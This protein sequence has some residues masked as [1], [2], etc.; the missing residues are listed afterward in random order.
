MQVEQATFTSAQRHNLQGYHLVARSQGIS[1]NLAQ[2]LSTWGPS[3]ASLTG[4]SRY[5][6]SLNVFPAGEGW[7]A[8][9]RTIFGGPEYSARGGLQVVT[10]Y[11]VFRAEQLAG[12]QNNFIAVARI[13]LALGE[14]RL[15]PEYSDRLPKVEFPDSSLLAEVPPPQRSYETSS[16][17]LPKLQ[18][19][20]SEYGPT[21]VVG[22]SNPLRLLEELIQSIPVEKRLHLSFTTGLNPSVHRPFHLHFLPEL[23]DS[24]Q[25]RLEEQG[26]TAL[27]S[28]LQ[29]VH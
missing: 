9:S 13:A 11:L 20:L 4:T 26:I 14:L 28:P 5:A 16:Q 8:L 7:Y 19:T 23:D 21:A 24:M 3:H 6:S 17:L 12:F 27:H 1:E 25:F 29:P 18:R 15:Q 2:T 10:R 22:E